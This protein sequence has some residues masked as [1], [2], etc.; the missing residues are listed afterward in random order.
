MTTQNWK[1]LIADHLLELLMVFIGVYA[2]FYLN[3][4]QLRQE[5]RQRHR[6]LII[7]LEKEAATR[8]KIDHEAARQLEQKRAD[9][10][11]RI[12]EGT[13][14]DL[15]ALNWRRLYDIADFNS[16]LQAGALDVLDLR[17]VAR[18]REVDAISRTGYAVM[19]NYQGL[20]NQLIV[21]HAGEGRDYFYDPGTKQLR[22]QFALYLES[23]QAGTQLLQQLSE[24]D[25]RLLAELTNERERFT[26]END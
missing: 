23:L 6:Q 20:T 13:M 2:A 14:P 22:R 5:Q 26:Q 24:A 21:L 19:A 9:L 11:A 12:D 15:E 7:Y 25:D 3:G 8:A 4:F 10:V 17:T 16:L 18:M 1:I